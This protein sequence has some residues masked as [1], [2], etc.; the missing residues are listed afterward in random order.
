MTDF[1]ISYT[2][3]DERWA[4]WIAFILEEDGHTTILQAWDFRPGSNFAIEMQKAAKRA[5]RTIMVLSPAYIKSGFASSEWAAA[6][7]NDPQGLEKK[8][9]PVVVEPC[10]VGGILGPIVHINL[11]GKS[12]TDAKDQLLSGVKTG[13][14]KPATRP[15]FP[16]P[17]G[18]PSFPGTVLSA[19]AKSKA[20]MPNVR[21]KLTDVEKR[22][23]L[24]DSFVEIG[25]YFETALSDLQSHVNGLEFDFRRL[26]VNEFTAE[27]F[28]NGK[29]VSSC[30][31]RQGN[32]GFGQDSI[33]Y[34]EGNINY[35]TNAANEIITLAK[36]DGEATLS[37]MM[38]SLNYGTAKVDFDTKRMSAEQGAEYLWRRFI[39]RLEY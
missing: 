27:I 18:T 4:S 15:A 2:S 13:R 12:E 38:D 22:R 32:E 26:S 7:A 8:L 30:R 3:A 34:D 1:F 25:N 20:Y 6:F 31:L 24:K 21:R 28:L 19:T 33:T 23:F 39:S 37:A 36:G 9:V 11:I 17:A 16:G 29:S 35:L 14:A 5:N 10:D